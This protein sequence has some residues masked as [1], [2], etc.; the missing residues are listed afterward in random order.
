LIVGRGGGSLE[1]LWAFNEELVIEAIFRS[2][3]PVISAVGH[4]TDFSLSDFVADVRAPTPSAA[5][6]IVLF[7][8]KEQIKLLLQFQNR[9]TS[10]FTQQLQGLRKRLTSLTKNPYLV[11]PYLLLSKRLQEL[12]DKKQ[13]LT[14]AIQTQIDRKKLLVAGAE[15]RKKILEPSYQI[16]LLHQKLQT[17][18]KNINLSIEQ[19]I[20]EKKNKLNS[21]SLYKQ[22]TNCFFTCF[23]RKK[24]RLNATISHLASIDPKNLLHKGYCILFSENQDSVILSLKQIAVAQNIK[25]LLQDGVVDTKVEKIHYGPAGKHPV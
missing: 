12:D 15:G 6:E 2:K 3:I 21:A 13:K 5:A 9:L 22:L 18:Q 10:H 20:K 25:I 16:S 24:E 23:Q 8:K 14:L 11:S 17:I 19:I 7:E 4:E 1:D